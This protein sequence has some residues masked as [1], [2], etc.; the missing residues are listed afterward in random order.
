MRPDE[1]GAHTET[2]GYSNGT[3]PPKKAVNGSSPNGYSSSH[4][5]N[6]S[7]PPQSNGT[8][9]RVS[10]VR[11][12]TYY[13]HNREEVTRILIQGL[14]D[15]GYAGTASNL[16]QE[17]GYELESPY[18]SAFRHAIL[19]GQWTEAEG[20]LLGSHPSDDGGEASDS[21]SAPGLV[22]AEGADKQQ[23]L[24]WIRQ[25]KF[26]ELLSKRD[27]S[28]ALMVLRQELTPLHQ[29]MHQLH[30]LSS[31][32]MC[33]Q[34]DLQAQAHWYGTIEETRKS[35]LQALT[36]CIAPSVMIRD[37]RLAE[38]L[39]QVKR[40][41]INECLYHNTSQSP[42]LYSDHHCE[43][44]KFPA[45]TQF[46]LEDHGG[47]VWHL[48][49]SHDGTKLATASED[50]S[51][52]VYRNLGDTFEMIHR[53][54][55]HDDAVTYLTW[56]PDDSKLITC[57]MDK[58]A[59]VWDVTSGEVILR[60][61]HRTPDNSHLTSASWGP[62]STSFVTSSFD[63]AT[64]L[65]LWTLEAAVDAPDH[66]LHKWSPGLRFQDCAI[67]P[68]GRRVVAT[69]SEKSLYVYDLGTYEEEYRLPFP[70]KLTSLTVSNDSK[71]MLV[72]LVSGE[73]QLLNV[74]TGELVRRYEG[75]KQEKFYIRSTFGGAAENFILSGSE[76]RSS[77]VNTELFTNCS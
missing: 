16:S 76:G 68:D 43:R 34:E 49:F 75:Q 9:K 60:V 23:M 35:L 61:D 51:V 7:S 17:S 33:P 30:A 71:T 20:I 3:S 14:I 32:L 38:L 4:E 11:S 19:E 22:L 74:V 52:I 62:D 72:N 5:M 48:E 39:D 47:E 73:I 10:P 24:F 26:L 53:L 29:D 54:R 59:R 67:T 40:N 64:P 18:V 2:N 56:S 13:G 55:D 27:L 8:T 31:L 21:R 66:L 25:Q 65:C 46:T 70:S 12:P 63:R 28:N 6:G 36:Q 15:M 57:S 37:H 69:D 45:L 50:K 77:H 44:E 1:T 41:Q 42:S 58:K